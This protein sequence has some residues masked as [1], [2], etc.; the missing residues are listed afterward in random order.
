M[1]EHEFWPFKDDRVREAVHIAIDGAGIAEAIHVIACRAV[2][3]P[4][5]K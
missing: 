1:P 2:L 5:R 3:Q 4:P